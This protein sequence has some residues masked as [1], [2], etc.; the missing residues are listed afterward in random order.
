MRILVTGISGF[1]G[2]YLAERL[3]KEGH[4]VAGFARQ[5]NRLNHPA[6]QRL[7]GKVQMYYGSITDAQAVKQ[8]MRD[9]QPEVVGHTAAISPVAYSFD[10]PHEVFETNAT[11]TI[12]VAEAALRECRNLKRFIFCSS[13][14]TYGRNSKRTAFTEEDAQIPSAPYGVAKVAA[15]KYVQYLAMAHNFPGVSFRQTNAY[16][17]KEND[18]FVVEAIITQ[19]LKGNICRLGEPAPVRNFIFIEDLLDLWT[20]MIHAGPEVN[21]H[22]FNTGPDNGLSICELAAKISGI[23]DWKGE[24]QWHTRPVRPGEIPYLNSSCE[25]AKQML[26]WEPKVSLTEGLSRTVDIW[27]ENLGIKS[28]AAS[29]D[30]SILAAQA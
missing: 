12:N 16:G 3:L 21:G 14:E 28:V 24:I 26:G 1:I 18:Y 22:V 23:M 30:R 19:M 15:E 27:A 29:F 25:K 20:K 4:E 5:T 9:Y 7:L 10:H 11:G 17:R 8:V 6:F 13:M 2:S